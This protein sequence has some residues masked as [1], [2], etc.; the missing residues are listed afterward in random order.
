MDSLREGRGMSRRCSFDQGRSRWF[1]LVGLSLV[2]QAPSGR[3]S[4]RDRIAYGTAREGPRGHL[5][6]SPPLPA[7]NRSRI[8][9]WRAP[10]RSHGLS[11]SW[12]CP[13]ERQ[14]AP[15]DRPHAATT[16]ACGAGIYCGTPEIVL[17]GTII[18]L[19]RFEIAPFRRPPTRTHGYTLPAPSMR[20]LSCTGAPGRL[21]AISIA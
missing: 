3:L 9:I 17:P 11:R 19:W 14:P 8:S 15:P 16:H 10:P 6:S 2:G 12:L 21:R 13:P 7:T 18:F 1:N 20:C 4:S 5:G